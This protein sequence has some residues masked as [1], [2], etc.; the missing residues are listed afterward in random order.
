MQI[1]TNHIT[2]TR[3]RNV[4]K[5]SEGKTRLVYNSQNVDVV[6]QP[7]ELDL[8]RIHDL[9]KIRWHYHRSRSELGIEIA[10]TVN[11]TDLLQRTGS[12]VNRLP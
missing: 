8:K 2:F 11:V 7:L 9:R 6:Y 3:V 5:F 4:I 10:V 12:T 1:V